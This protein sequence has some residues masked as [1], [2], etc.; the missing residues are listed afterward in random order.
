[1]NF[2]L[3]VTVFIRKETPLPLPNW[4]ASVAQFVGHLHGMQ[5]VVGSTP[6]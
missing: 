2:V 6:A 5:Y 1:M 4:T 3:S